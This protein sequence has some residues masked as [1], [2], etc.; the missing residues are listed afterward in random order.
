MAQQSLNFSLEKEKLR[1]ELY[2][3]LSQGINK[4]GESNHTPLEHE[5]LYYG[6][7]LCERGGLY[8]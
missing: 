6:D 4:N 3:L 5:A 8:Y 1:H 7:T 2:T